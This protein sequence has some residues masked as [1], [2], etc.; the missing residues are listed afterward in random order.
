[1]IDLERAR[2]SIRDAAAPHY[3]GHVEIVSGVL[4]EAVG[5]PAAIGEL[6][7]IQRGNSSVNA[8]VVG[9]RGATTLLMPHGDIAGIA[10]MQRVIALKRPFSVPVGEHL[11]GR[12]L[13]GFA[14]PLDGLPAP[15]QNE[16]R[17]ARS[18]S[19]DPLDRAP[20]D[21]A[22]QTGVRAIDGMLTLGRGQRVGVFA[23]SGVGKST[24]LGQVTRG[25][26]AQ[27]IVVCLVGERGREVRAFLDEVLGEEGRRKSVVVVSTSDRPPIERFM[28]PF[29]A[30]TIAEYFR[31][32][33]RE[34]LLVM[35]SVTRFA[36]ASRE[37]GL[38]AGEPPTVR[39]FP[40]SFFATVP[41]LVER[42]GRTHKGSITGLLTILLDGDDV[43]DP[44]AD[45]LRGLLD[46]HIVLSRDLA[47]R[48]HYPAI[49]VLASLSRLMPSLAAPADMANASVLRELLASWREGRDLIE[50]GAYKA[51]S[52]PRLDAAV[53]LK[54]ALDL[55][56]KQGVR[57]ST[58]LADTRQ[59]I[60]R[61]AQSANAP[62][63]AAAEN[64]K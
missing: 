2:T 12:V 40:P 26:D 43:N 61:I 18:N 1:M 59:F 27:V 44:V 33:G 46:G 37:I 64:K 55:F 36:A 8:E 45:T 4:V 60:A 54:P 38:A 35:D 47:Q 49:D 22:L 56:L 42:M 52:N 39:G 25:S 14:H 51:G 21:R 23:G 17:P 7:R 16:L 20:I 53:R 62:A 32:L 29:V 24:L 15:S 13:D 3:R 50:I 28:A 63:A 19:P 58:A 10:P 34:V 6:C 48:G 30:V 57:D 41:K 11:L 5:V 31:D 9:F